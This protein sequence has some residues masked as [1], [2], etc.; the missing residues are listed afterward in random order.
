MKFTSQ[1]CY[2]VK[3]HNEKVRCKRY[4]TF[5]YDIETFWTDPK[6]KNFCIAQVQYLKWKKLET[7]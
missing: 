7:T 6:F 5:F 1:Q 4:P 2:S 3:C